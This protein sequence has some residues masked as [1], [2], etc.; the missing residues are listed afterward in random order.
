MINRG[1]YCHRSA[2]ARDPL[3]GYSGAQE[4][5]LGCGPAGIRSDEGA[6]DSVRVRE[7]MVGSSLINRIHIC[8]FIKIIRI[9]RLI[10]NI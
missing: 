6:D 2:K 7:A 5:L 10:I 4:S 9:S 8:I 1:L 3:G